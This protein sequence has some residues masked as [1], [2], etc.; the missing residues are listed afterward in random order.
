MKSKKIILTICIT[1]IFVVTIIALIILSNLGAKVRTGYLTDFNLNIKRTLKLNNLE[2]IMTNY[3]I[4]DK[5]DEES[6]K[7]YFLTNEN[8]TNYVHQFRIRYYDKIFRNNDIYGVYPDLSNLPDYM[9]NA[10]MEGAGSPYGNFIYGKKMLEIEKIDNISYILKLK[11]NQFFIY[12]IL[13]IV[14]VL[15]YLINF[16]KKIRELLTCNNIT[17]LDLAIFIVISVFCFLSF[18]QGD[19]FHTVAS[20]FTYLNGHIFDFYKYNTTLEYIKLNNYMPSTYILFAI[21]NFPIKLL[22]SMDGS[23]IGLG[24]IWYNKI[25]TSLFYVASA[26]V[27][28]KICKV[29][30]F[31]DKKSKITSFL[32]LTTPIAMFSQ[33]IFGQYDIFTVFFT[34]LGVYFYFKNDDFKFALFFSIALTFKYFPA[35]VFIILLIYREKNIIKIIKQCTIFIIPFAIE[36]LIYISD[37]AFRE[38]VFGFRANSFIFGLTLKTEYGMNIKIFLM[39][40]IFICGYTYFNEVKNK[41]EN[42]KYI[43]Y[44]LSLVSFMLFGLSYWH[45]Q[46]VIFITPFLVFGTVINKKSDIFILLDIFLMLFFISFTVNIYVG[47]LDARLLSRGIFSSILLDIDIR[48]FHLYMRD[49]F[50]DSNSISYTFFSG[51]LLLNALFKHPKYDF[52]NINEDI[53]DA[54]PYIRLRLVI[55]IMIFIIPCFISALS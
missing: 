28:Y 38:G 39:F 47:G 8:I 54:M 19:M 11:Y 30:A 37:F 18:Q 36:L 33:F 6:I 12:L 49:I 27:I 2:N 24:I 55:G 53:S 16:N 44:Y 21:W 9:E 25:L 20:S 17:R 43:F 42:E 23:N 45:P 52:D 5:L 1:F 40:W 10:E 34:L 14:I 41:S 4:D 22:F 15:Y 7:N 26:I 32:W 51:L 29:I 50:I 3:I 48:D 31:D 46:W 35:F 13:L